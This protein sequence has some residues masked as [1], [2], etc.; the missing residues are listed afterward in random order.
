MYK[1]SLVENITHFMLSAQKYDGIFRHEN[2]NMLY[3]ECLM[4]LGGIEG[5]R[6]FYEDGISKFS[7]IW[8]SQ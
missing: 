4:I 3:S 1:E 7:Q 8:E 5:E 2:E 6:I